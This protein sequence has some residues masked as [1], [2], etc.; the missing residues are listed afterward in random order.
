MPNFQHADWLIND[1]E[2]L[3]HDEELTRIKA[4]LGESG[5]DLSANNA[6]GTE[7]AEAEDPA[8]A[9]S[10]QEVAAKVQYLYGDDLGHGRVN[11]KNKPTHPDG[12]KSD[13]IN[14]DSGPHIMKILRQILSDYPG[15]SPAVDHLTLDKPFEP[16]FHHWDDFCQAVEQSDDFTK[17]HV[18]GFV[19][20]L[21]EELAPYFEVLNNADAHGIIEHQNLWTIFAP[22]QLVWTDLKQHHSIGEV[23]QAK[24]DRFTGD[25]VVSY[26]QTVWDGFEL[27]AKSGAVG[28]P[29]F[30]G[31]R[32][33]AGLQA[34]PFLR[35]PDAADIEKVVLDRGRKFLGLLGCLPGVPGLWSV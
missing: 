4:S 21:K 8:P 16:M 6:Q 12:P 22:H 11:W 1:D 2:M 10:T 17:Q 29:S 34:I 28:I 3:W 20:F 7:D 25:F 27:K 23:E 18:E 26:K 24:S 31:T 14:K 19:M 30:T 15:V 33:I 9:D 13:L 5:I 32:A 35:K